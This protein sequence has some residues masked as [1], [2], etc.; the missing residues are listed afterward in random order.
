MQIHQT[1]IGPAT[2]LRLYGDLDSF[3]SNY[4]K[5]HISRLFNEGIFKIVVDLSDV[6]FVD[7][8]GLGQLVGALKMCFHHDGNLL[9][10]GINDSVSDLLRLTKLDTVFRVFDTVEDAAASFP[11]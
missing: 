9:L 3:S 6:S 11:E 2:V 8:A 4:L 7:S 1:T 10:V 5:E